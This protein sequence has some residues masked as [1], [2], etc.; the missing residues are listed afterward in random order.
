MVI[1]HCT[2]FFLQ[3]LSKEDDQFWVSLNDSLRNSVGKVMA[4]YYQA[5]I[6]EQMV[7]R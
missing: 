5:L 1:V 7:I 2:K 6:G 3:N 4:N